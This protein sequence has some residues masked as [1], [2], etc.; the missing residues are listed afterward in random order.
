MT[1]SSPYTYIENGKNVIS[2][3]VITNNSTYNLWYK[4]NA[5]INQSSDIFLAASIIPSMWMNENIEIKERISPFL[6]SNIDKIQNILCDWYPEANKISVNST[7]G[8]DKYTDNR[9]VAC[10]FTGGVDSFYTLMKHI[11]EID[12]IIYVHGFDAWLYETEYLSMVSK[13][14]NQVAKEMNKEIIEVESNIHPFGDKYV[15]WG[16]QYFGSALA[17]VAILLSSNIRKVYI[18]SGKDSNNLIPCGSH[19]DLDYLWSTENVEIVHDGCEAT[20][21]DKIKSIIHNESALNH[22]RVCFDRTNGL[23]NCS[24]CEKCIRTM[25][26]LNL[27]GVLDKCKTFDKL[28]ISLIPGIIIEKNTLLYAIENY[29]ELPDGDI[30]EYLKSAID[31]YNRLKNR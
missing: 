22:L 28:D 26:S 27:L 25:I 11:D 10:F 15:N 31:N 29:N 23:Y 24:V 12:V 4:T 30:K 9:K 6:Y 21:L 13:H 7:L 5:S 16:F 2:C 17:S 18:G 14:M 19:P 1:I 3:D 8:Y 20:R